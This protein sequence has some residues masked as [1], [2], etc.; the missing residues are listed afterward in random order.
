M[1]GQRS[2]T[3]GFIMFLLLIR[4]SPTC[5]RRLAVRFRLGLDCARDDEARERYVWFYNV[6]YR[7][8]VFFVKQ[9]R[10]ARLAAG[11]GRP[12][13]PRRFYARQSIVV[14]KRYNLGRTGASAPTCS[15]ESKYGHRRFAIGGARNVLIKAF[16]LGGR[17]IAEAIAKARRMRGRAIT[18]VT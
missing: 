12:A 2:V 13:L 14:L 5:Q 3:S 17:W 4:A 1:T 15:T 10:S 16:P 18:I 9:E 11:R 6:R 7:G 8:I